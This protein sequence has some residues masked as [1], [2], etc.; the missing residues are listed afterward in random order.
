M[1]NSINHFKQKFLSFL[2][3]GALLLSILIL[4]SS[5]LITK[6]KTSV[7][8]PAALAS[9]DT[10]ALSKSS[11]PIPFGPFHFGERAS[12]YDYVKDSVKAGDIFT[13]GFISLDPRNTVPEVESILTTARNQGKKV[14]V[15]L[16]KSDPCYYWNSSTFNQTQFLS[17]VGVFVPTLSKYKDVVIGILLLNEPHNPDRGCTPVPPLELYNVAKLIRTTLLANVFSPSFLLG[18][19]SHPAYFN[20]VP[21]D[22]TINFSNTQ[23]A[24]QKG[25]IQE[26][27]TS[28]ETAASS[29]RQRLYFTVNALS[30]GINLDDDLLYICQNIH[31]GRVAMVGYWTWNTTGGNQT[32]P[33]SDLAKVKDACN[34]RTN[35][36]TPTQTAT[37]TEPLNT[38]NIAEMPVGFTLRG[39]DKNTDW[40]QLSKDHLKSGDHVVIPSASYQLVHQI[41][42]GLIKVLFLPSMSRGGLNE[43]DDWI[44]AIQATDYLSIDDTKPDEVDYLVTIASKYNKKVLLG[45]TGK[46][47]EVYGPQMVK[48]ADAVLIQ[49]QRWFIDDSSADLNQFTTQVHQTITLMK[50]TNP[51]LEFWVQVGRREDRGGGTAD[52]FI[53]AYTT[54]KSKYPS[55][56]QVI[57]PFITA[58]AEAGSKQGVEALLEFLKALGR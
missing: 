26:F 2:T 19:G 13:G 30:D 35:Q 51:K 28:Q 42:S 46:N 52:D 12:D 17:D 31:R 20:S 5:V 58:T 32:I 4:G 25:T 39:K 10:M 53:R 55:D 21:V 16:A 57:H 34:G 7:R 44:K 9:S 47:A 48:S 41:P 8:S 15:N 49:A 18:F 54:L 56:F 23:Y 22:G 36:I 27:L 40:L 29:V 38:L 14:I 33:L 6:Q 1:S 37:V 24:P 43:T 3:L 50:S 45:M 11:G